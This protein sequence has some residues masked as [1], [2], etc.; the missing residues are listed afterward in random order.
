MI[1]RNLAS[2]VRSL[3]I[4]ADY[5]APDVA[6][7]AL[8]VPKRVLCFCPPVTRLHPY[9]FQHHRTMLI[10]ATQGRGHIMVNERIFSLQPGE[11][12][13]VLPFQRHCYFDVDP[14]VIWLFVSFEL[15]PP[16]HPEHMP[17]RLEREDYALLD[18]VLTEYR[19][20]MG[21]EHQSNGLR[22]LLALLLDHLLGSPEPKAPR[23][24][25]ED[26]HF[27]ERVNAV[28][29]QWLDRSFTI[30]ELARE[31]HVSES[32]LRQKYRQL[33]GMS[34]GRHVREAR[35]H[36]ACDLLGN[37]D[38]SVTDIAEA[39]G[40][41]SL[42]SFSRSFKNTLGKSPLAYRTFVRGRKR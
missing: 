15:D 20:C 25:S 27:L 12:L 16:P 5:F 39:C 24:M 1:P 6:V 7:E 40:Y 10:V 4:P 8:H 22:L 35:M 42:F 34:L 29:F 31:L 41:D 36:H 37:T 19:A 28:V 21:K 2:Q 11:A 32:S 17:F 3:P 18:Q 13:L 14:E 9:E 23:R 30:A 38:D 26:L 33:S